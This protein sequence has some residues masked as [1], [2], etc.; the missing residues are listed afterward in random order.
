MGLGLD[1]VL[2]DVLFVV[3][4]LGMHQELLLLLQPCLDFE[5]NLGRDMLS[6]ARVLPEFAQLLKFI[7]EL[8]ESLPAIFD[9]YDFL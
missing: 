8:L 1:H 3:N 2:S 7:L 6:L 4:Q 5:N 9:H